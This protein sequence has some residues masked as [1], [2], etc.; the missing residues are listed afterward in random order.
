MQTTIRIFFGLGLMFVITGCAQLTVE[1]THSA[2]PV[3]A[4]FGIV[5]PTYAQTLENSFL[6]EPT[7][8]LNAKM[9]AAIQGE[10]FVDENGNGERD[11]GEPGIPKMRFV[12]AGNAVSQASDAQGEFTFN[13]VA[14]GQQAVS[15]DELTIPSGYRLTT[16]A[17]IPIFLC[18]GDRGFAEFGIQEAPDK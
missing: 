9:P 11:Q 13:A 4:T 17:T 14:P 18:E 5:G 8:R 10:V 1:L 6:L 15:L 2:R 7:S 16:A 3:P 12:L